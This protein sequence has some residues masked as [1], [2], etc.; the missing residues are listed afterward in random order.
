MS[1]V[2]RRRRECAAYQHA[3]ILEEEANV[4][5]PEDGVPDS[6]A[7]CAQELDGLEEAPVQLSGPASRVPER[8][9][10]EDAGEGSES[11]CEDERA[12]EPVGA[13]ELSLQ[14][15][16]ENVATAS[17]A[18]D[19]SQ[20]PDGAQLFEAM[21]AKMSEMERQA[22]IIAKR[23][24]VARIEDNDGL[25]QPVA[26]E[27]G[28]QLLREIVLDVQTV[29]STLSR[30]GKLEVERA[31]Q[32]AEEL[33]EV[34]PVALS[35]PSGVQPLSAWDARTW[36][37]CFTEW[38]FGDG[39]PNLQRDRP[40]LFEEVAAMLLEREE[41][42]Y[43]LE[44]EEERYEARSPSRFV[45]PEIVAILGDVRRRLALLKGTRA[46]TQRRGYAAD[47]SRANVEDY[48]KALGIAGAHDGVLAGLAR[49][50]MPAAVKTALR[51]LLLSTSNVP[52]TEGRKVALRHNGHGNNLFFG[53]STYFCTPNFPDTYS[54]LML[55]LDEGPGSCAHLENSGALQPAAVATS[56]SQLD[57]GGRRAAPNGRGLWDS[58][59]EIVRPEPRMPSLERMHQITASNP[60]A[61]AKFFM[62]QTELHY[63]H[64]CGLERLF[65]GRRRLAGVP[66]GFSAVHDCCA[67]SLQPSVTPAAEDVQAPFESQARGFAH[68]HGKGHSRIGAT[69]RWLRNSLRGSGEALLERVRD[70]RTAL[71]AVAVTVQYE[72]AREPGRQLGVVLRPEPFT[73]LQQRQSRMDGGEEDDG[74]LRDLVPV[75]PP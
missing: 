20:D 28:R 60:R 38:W 68:G 43:Q 17:I 67:S 51:T 36:P 49:P 58:A 69:V 21:K 6:V 44:N 4:R 18:V 53:A 66:G 8:P 24:S 64:V 57:Y 12:V 25:L 56:P 73:A 52:G 62:L 48:E 7:N 37:V 35:V 5:L 34:N 71:L 29:A 55:L 30:R 15:M 61:Q 14:E 40:M 65:I 10:H 42:E 50:D 75:S 63:R 39:A 31:C 74:T 22:L 26:D 1:L 9:R 16:T 70:L 32:N 13:Q 2:R 11:S 3:Q 54:P 72:A 45:A 41:L 23:E 47:L 27:G 33:R 59:L 46:A 19:P